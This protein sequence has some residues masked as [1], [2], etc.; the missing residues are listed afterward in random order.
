MNSGIFKDTPG[1]IY[2][3]IWLK[4][5]IHSLYCYFHSNVDNK[6]LIHKGL[7][8]IK[9]KPRPVA[10]APPDDIFPVYD[11]QPVP[12][13]DDYITDPQYPTEAYF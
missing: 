12:C 1:I 6:I 11:E 5:G 8:E 2:S 7:R 9:R 4:G 13:I 3:H 10:N